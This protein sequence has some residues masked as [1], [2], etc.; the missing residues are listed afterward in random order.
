MDSS[1]TVLLGQINLP[2][3]IRHGNIPPANYR[4]C[5]GTF[6]CL[7][8]QVIIN[9]IN[10][11]QVHNYSFMPLQIRPG[12]QCTRNTRVTLLCSADCPIVNSVP[13]QRLIQ[14]VHRRL[15]LPLSATLLCCSSAQHEACSTVRLS[16]VHI[17]EGQR[18]PAAKDDMRWSQPGSSRVWT[19]VA[20]A[21]VQDA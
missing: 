14:R 21:A 6:S 12:K 5:F 4:S 3:D 8:L 19:D 15:G 13:L 9:P 11:R 17:P 7:S 16:A 2:K 20:H 18:R 1:L 10:K